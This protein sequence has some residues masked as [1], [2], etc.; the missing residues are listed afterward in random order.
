MCACMCVCVGMCAR[1]CVCVCV[2]VCMCGCAGHYTAR[3]AYGKFPI[4]NVLGDILHS[5]QEV[6]GHVLRGILQGNVLSRTSYCD[7]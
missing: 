6:S 2:C 4:V 3:L 1:M 7:S 5:E